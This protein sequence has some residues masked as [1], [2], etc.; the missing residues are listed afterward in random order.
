MPS[1]NTAHRLVL[2]HACLVLAAAFLGVFS[3]AGG[4][5]HVPLHNNKKATAAAQGMAALELHG[6]LVHA[7]R[8][9]ATPP[10]LVR[11]PSPSSSPPV[12]MPPHAA[13]VPLSEIHTTAALGTGS[14]AK[15]AR[16]KVLGGHGR[17]GPG[18]IS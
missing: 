17:H 4:R 1:V 15:S 11:A 14:L 18:S 6:V 9:G 16:W 7:D 2:L 3:A 10:P 12:S 8:A 13:W 5:H